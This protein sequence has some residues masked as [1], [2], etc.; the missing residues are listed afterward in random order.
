MVRVLIDTL[1]LDQTLIEIEIDTQLTLDTS[2]PQHSI[3]FRQR[4]K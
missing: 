4:V 3:D 1:T 2:L